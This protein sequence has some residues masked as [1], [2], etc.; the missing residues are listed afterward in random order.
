M[1]SVSIQLSGAIVK[2]I[3]DQYETA[4]GSIYET[5]WEQILEL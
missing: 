1:K 5:L 3:W 2:P 4:A